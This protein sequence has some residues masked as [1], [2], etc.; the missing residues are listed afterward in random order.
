V[1][2]SWPA[3][4]N[5][6]RRVVTDARNRTELADDL[7]RL[8]SLTELA[9]TRLLTSVEVYCLVAAA[10]RLVAQVEAE[11]CAPDEPSLPAAQGGE[12]DR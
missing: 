9:S 3:G 5:L 11:R 2:G 10:R 1:A 8:R 12:P 7:R 4:S 6:G